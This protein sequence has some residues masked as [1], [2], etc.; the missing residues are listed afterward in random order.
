MYAPEPAP[1]EACFAI[2][3][4]CFCHVAFTFGAA[5]GK[6]RPFPEKIW[7]KCHGNAWPF[8]WKCVPLHS[9]SPRKGGAGI[10]LWKICIT[11]GSTR[12]QASAKWCLG[13]NDEPSMSRRP[14]SGLRRGQDMNGSE[15]GF[16]ADGLYL[17]WRLLLFLR[18]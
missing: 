13:M 12:V 15:C 6:F 1:Q 3:E 7:K 2:W 11:T 16:R 4:G 9:L 8:R 10:V 5:R 14:V 17:L 18:L